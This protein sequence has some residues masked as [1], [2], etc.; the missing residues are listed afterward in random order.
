MKKKRRALDDCN[1]QNIAETSLNLGNFY[2]ENR[3]YEKALIEY[4]DEAKAY[5]NLGKELDEAKSHR[6]IGEM[7]MLLGEFEEALNHEKI[8]LSND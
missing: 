3:Q 6:M 7:H 2:H 1:L 5:K 8:Y 4:K